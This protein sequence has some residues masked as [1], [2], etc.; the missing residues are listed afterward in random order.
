MKNKKIFGV[1]ALVLALLFTVCVFVACGEPADEPGGESTVK[2]IEVT[3]MPKTEFTLGEDFTAEGG[4]L[5]VTYEDGTTEKVS[6]TA[7]G[8][9]VTAP[10]MSTEGANKNVVVRYEGARATYKISVSAAMFTVTFDLGDSETTAEVKDGETVAKPDD[11]TLTGHTFDGWYTAEAGG[12]PYDFASPV[13]ADITLYAYWT[14][15]GVTYHDFTFDYNDGVGGLDSTTVV[16]HIADGEVAVA[17]VSDPVREGYAFL[18]WFTTDDGEDEYDFSSEVR[19]DVTVYAQWERTSMEPVQYTFEVEDIVLED[20]TTGQALTGPG[21]SGTGTGPSMLIADDGTHGVSNGYFISF[22]YKSGIDLRFEIISDMDVEN[23]QL[24]VR[25][26]A[27][28]RDRSFNQSNY[29]ISVNGTQ[30]PEYNVSITDVPGYVYEGVSCAPFQDYVIGNVTLYEGRNYI[31]LVT[32]N[33][34]GDAGSTRTASAPLIDCIKITTEAVL[35]WNTSL[36]YP[37]ENY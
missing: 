1:F 32:N 4:E 31:D 20:P 27:E 7:E 28:G 16:H 19:G 24:V 34:D 23:A 37:A 25:M 14:E 6:L 36:G 9:E 33:N 5:T 18:G 29:V 26:S 22:L 3:T 21:N 13:T 12:L 11:P 15:D 17:L 30:T 8:V 10:D 35:T 2:S